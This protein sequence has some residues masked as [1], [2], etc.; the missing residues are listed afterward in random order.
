MN[1]F[2]QSHENPFAPNNQIIFRVFGDDIP[3]GELFEGLSQDD[4]LDGMEGEQHY[5]YIRGV[6]VAIGP[7]RTRNCIA[8][9]DDEHGD[10]AKEAVELLKKFA[11]GKLTCAPSNADKTEYIAFCDGMTYSFQFWA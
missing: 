7:D 5:V 11:E 9:L 6:K 1:A 4:I 2:K 3:G 8:V 10:A